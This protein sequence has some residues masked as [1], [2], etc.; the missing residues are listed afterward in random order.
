MP[1]TNFLKMK[2]NLLFLALFL[3]VLS[4]AGQTAADYYLPFKVGNRTMLQ[5]SSASGS[6]CFRNTEYKYRWM[7]E[8]NGVDYFVEQG[9]EGNYT[10]G[11]C[12]GDLYFRYLWIRPDQE[13]NIVAGAYSM[14]GDDNGA[15][16]SL[17]NAIIPSTPVIIF[18]NEFLT[19]G[20]SLTTQINETTTSTDMVISV[21]AQVETQAGSFS[22]CIQVRNTVKTNGIITFMEDSYYAFHVGLVQQVRTIPEGDGHVDGLEFYFAGSDKTVHC[23]AGGLPSV[24]SD[25]EKENI[26]SLT[27]TGTMDARDFKTIRDEIPNLC[28]LNLGDVEIAEYTGDQGPAPEFFTYLANEI[29]RKS[30]YKLGEYNYYL[31]SVILPKNISS[32]GNLAFEHCIA[33]GQISFPP[34]LTS[35]GLQAFL[36]CTNLD[37]IIFE[38]PVS[39]AG[40]GK[41]A[42]GFCSKLESFEIPESVTYIDTVAFLGSSASITVQE[43]N[44]AYSAEGGVLFNKDKT[45]LIYVPNTRAGDY[46]IPSS[47][48]VV[49]V[50]AFYNCRKLKSVTMPNT[51]TTLEIWAFENCSG[52]E[53]ISLPSSLN[54]IAGF[55]FYN[56][57]GLNSVYANAPIPPDL[58]ESDSVFFNVDKNLC[59]LYVPAGSREAYQAADQWKDFLLIEEFVPEQMMYYQADLD[60]SWQMHSLLADNPDDENSLAGWMY[61]TNSIDDDGQSVTA[62]LVLNGIDQPDFSSSV[63]VAAGGGISVPG[64][65]MDG[66]M[67]PGKQRIVITGTDGSGAFNFTVLQ[68]TGH[69]TDCEIADLE[70]TWQMHSLVTNDY[71]GS[72]NW[73]GWTHGVITI[74]D[75]GNTATSE[76]I[77]NGES[78]AGESSSLAISDEG[79][80]SSPEND[81]HGFLDADKQMAVLTMTDNSGG[82][83]LSFLQKAVSDTIYGLHNLKGAWR[84]HSLV[85]DNPSEPDD[86]SGWIHGLVTVDEKGESAATNI[87]ANGESR[88]G[89]TSSMSVSTSG[90]VTIAGTDMHG[91]MSADMQTIVLT[92]TDQ[93][94]GYNLSVMIRDYNSDATGIGETPATIPLFTAFPN[95]AS[96]KV[97]IES[98]KGALIEI[99]NMQGELIKRTLTEGGITEINISSFPKG[100]YFVRKKTPEGTFS[101]KLIRQ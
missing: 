88:P 37:K 71:G 85:T 21:H 3:A 89:F 32:I 27:I 36:G 6:W 15:S 80:I 76:L 5:T 20:A 22:D 34:S 25:P 45:A 84:L 99:F 79:I 69:E 54:S 24:L 13:G 96:E 50:D 92:G 61:G 52:L 91:Y 42:F 17:V 57:T 39:V 65:D 53:S 48:E 81:I 73:A 51:L 98:T 10:T 74:D 23:T 94:K 43:N 2:I 46:E 47:V 60:G 83:S 26:S 7:E 97:C 64:T 93:G 58:S 40:I 31:Y 8:V 67:E 72:N 70:G 77:V 16:P 35:I 11:N 100:L 66:F 12:T 9:W 41:Y 87:I 29:P 59:V 82:Y 78:A 62:N 38:P 19:E 4:S 86:W 95:P 18:P 14:A 63:L 101:C 30:F 49:K 56:C 90:I 1:N 44:P 75:L 68:K 33:L 28:Y 55:A